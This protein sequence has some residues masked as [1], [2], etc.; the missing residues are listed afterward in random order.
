MFDAVAIHDDVGR[1]AEEAQAWAIGGKIDD[2]ADVC[3]VE[4]QCV[5]SVLS[6]DQVIPV[7]R[8]PDELIIALSAKHFVFTATANES[9]VTWPTH[10]AVVARAAEKHVVAGASVEDIVAGASGKRIVSVAA[11]E[12]GARHGSVNVIDFEDIV[13]F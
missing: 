8:V 12:V 7:S 13:T 1:V 5:H 11:K 10:K 2:F 3:A 4:E 9:V 6:L